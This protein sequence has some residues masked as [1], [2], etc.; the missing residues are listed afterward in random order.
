MTQHTSICACLHLL[1]CFFFGMLSVPVFLFFFRWELFS[2]IWFTNKNTQKLSFLLLF[3]LTMLFSDETKR[4]CRFFFY[5]CMCVLHCLVSKLLCMLT[6]VQCHL[7]TMSIIVFDLLWCM[8]VT[9]QLF[10]PVSP[11]FQH[12]FLRFSSLSDLLFW[13]IEERTGKWIEEQRRSK[14]HS[15]T[16]FLR[17]FFKLFFC[18]LKVIHKKEK[19]HKPPSPPKNNNSLLYP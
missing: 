6:W 16:R 15:R 18:F 14:V 3:F 10:Q 19:N 13:N 8:C 12:P 17:R 1:P 2:L 5:D 11:G 4:G 7:A 9:V